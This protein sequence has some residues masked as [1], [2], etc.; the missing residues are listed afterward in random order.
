MITNIKDA[1]QTILKEITEFKGV[2]NYEPGK[3]GIPSKLPACTIATTGM[4]ECIPSEVAGMDR[5]YNVVIKGY[6]KLVDAEDTQK[7]LDNIIDM[8]LD[9]LQKY[10]SINKSCDSFVITGSDVVHLIARKN[11]VSVINFYLNITEEVTL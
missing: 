9:V 8:V 1:L 10:P 4:S 5:V 6:V 2:Y 11:P 3:E 7:D